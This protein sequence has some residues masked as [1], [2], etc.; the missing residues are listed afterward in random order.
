MKESDYV[1][2]RGGLQILSVFMFLLGLFLINEGYKTPESVTHITGIIEMKTVTKEPDYGIKYNHGPTYTFVFKLN[3]LSEYLGIPLGTYKFAISGINYYNNLFQI[4]QP[5]EVY[6]DN[7][8]FTKSKNL[9]CWIHK[10]NY[11]GKTVYQ[12]NEKKELI[13]GVVF[14][15]MS[16]AAVGALFYLKRR[17]ERE[18]YNLV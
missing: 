7:N 14:L 5:I 10:I 15:G 2:R 1:Y 11:Q 9:T 12:V 3:N 18:K 17:F 13:P 16:F 4:G 8:V 6:Y